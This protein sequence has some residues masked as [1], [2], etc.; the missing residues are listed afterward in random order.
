MKQKTSEALRKKNTGATFTPEKLA[1][2]LAERISQHLKK[3]NAVIVDPAC[4]D[5]ELLW[6]MGK[7]L[8][9][10]NISFSLTGFDSHNESLQTAQNR[11][12]QLPAGSLNLIHGDFLNMSLDSN[13]ILDGPSSTLHH[14]T[15]KNA[16]I[17][18]ANPPYV[19]TQILGSEFAQI[20]SKKFNL[21]GRV[22]LYHAFII[23]MT[24]ILKTNGILG[25][26][27]SNKYLTN[28]SGESIRKFFHDNFEILEIIDLGDTKLFEAAVLPSI[29]IGKKLSDKKSDCEAGQFTK[30]YQELNGFSGQYVSAQDIYQ[31]LRDENAGYFSIGTKKYKKTT[32]YLKYHES[33]C[34]WKMLSTKELEWISKIQDASPYKVSDFFKVRVGI[35]TTA[36]NIFIRK[37][38]EKLGDKKPESD[39]LRELIS[40]ENITR[41][42]RTASKSLEVLYPYKWDKGF[43]EVIK[44]SEYPKS[45]NYLQTH[46]AQLSG[47]T[48]VIEAG[49]QWYEIWVPQNPLLWQNPKLV[50][51]DISSEPRFYFDTSGKIVNGNCYWIAAEKEIDLETLLLVQGVANSKL[52]T[53]YHDLFFPNKL[54][55][56]KRRYF[57]Q[58]V[59]EYPLPP[60]DNIASRETIE[61]VKRINAEKDLRKIANYEKQIESK[62]AAAFQVDPVLSLY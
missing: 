6:A 34:Q 50:F 1:E 38:W 24:Q 42:N 25:V 30:L 35:K 40:Q 22:D 37:D 13:G 52:M 16:D 18:I 27:T 45:N 20:L 43:K 41:W 28:K 15:F 60:I 31:V 33:E 61:L 51:P 21:K 58:Y 3:S 54:Y 44:L 29:F 8:L 26:I 2:F 48:Y 12:Q 19:R 7:N 55:S 17:I 5:G 14:Q 32:G 53:V 62:I 49:K 47:R 4:G 57:S 10:S 11:L 23:G 39:I 46:R 36:D 59:E 9:D 56:G